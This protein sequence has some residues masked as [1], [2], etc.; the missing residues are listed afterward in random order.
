M[1]V[2]I[3]GPKEKQEY[4][5]MEAEKLRK[6]AEAAEKDENYPEAKRLRTLAEKLEADAKVL[7]KQLKNM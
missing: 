2:I 6:Q 7:E 3:G 5:I 4:Y 1:S